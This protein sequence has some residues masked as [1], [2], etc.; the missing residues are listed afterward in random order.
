MTSSFTLGQVQHPDRAFETGCH[1]CGCQLGIRAQRQKEARDLHVVEQPFITARQRGPHVLAMRWAVPL[2]CRRHGS[3]IRG[4]PHECR[5]HAV[6]LANQLADIQ[7]AALAHLGR[8]RVAEMRVVRPYHHTCTRTHAIEIAQQLPERVDHVAIAQVPRL[9]TPPEHRPVV[10]FGVPH[11]PRILLGIEEVVG[12]HSPI[13]AR[14]LGPFVVELEQLRHDVAF[15]RRV[16]AETGRIAVLLHFLAK[17]IEAPVPPARPTGRLRVHL[18]EKGEH[19]L[20]R[21]SKAIQIQPVEAGTLVRRL[22]LV[23]GPQPADEVEHVGVA[24]H[25]RREASEIGER[26]DG[27]LI[28]AR[29]AH[30]AID[31]VRVRPVGL[32]GDRGESLLGNQTPCDERTLSVELVG[33][34]RCVAKQHD[35]RVANAFEQGVILRWITAQATRM[36]TYDVESI[37]RT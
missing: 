5:P 18:V 7:L 21:R 35:S 10:R 20:H 15:T 6:R 12:R 2:R 17:L 27:F 4:R 9:G 22:P 30:V 36:C 11:Q 31:P 8:P 33:P 28:T 32:N 16:Q 1:E 25:P 19:R 34:M 3:R 23:V 24:P 13:A 14:V 26:L 37:A 29:S